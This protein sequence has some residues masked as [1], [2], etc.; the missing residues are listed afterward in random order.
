MKVSP[1]IRKCAAIFDLDGTLFDSMPFVIESFIY[2]VTP[3]RDPPTAAEVVSQ[4]GGPL[5]SCLRNL[6]GPLAIESL[7][8][9]KELLLNYEHGKEDT[10]K[11]FAGARELLTTL[12]ARQVRLGVWT[13]RDRWSAVKILDTHGFL[14][15]FQA[16]V[17]GDD[18]PT[19]KPDPEGLLHAIELVGAAAVETVFVG[20]ADADVMGGHAAGVHTIFVHHGRIAPA[21]IHSRA[22]EVFAEPGEAY[23]AVLRHFTS[24][25]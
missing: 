16:T 3:F 18:M 11:P 1:S 4:L 15:F 9:A 8:A 21:H 12:Q 7:P 25:A 23:A 5:E 10:L 24:C 13:G 6:L 22:A 17:C 20:D 19:H 14:G 2:A